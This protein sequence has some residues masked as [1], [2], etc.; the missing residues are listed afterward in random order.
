MAAKSDANLLW[1]GGTQGV[2]HQR[3]ESHK[4][5]NVPEGQDDAPT[6]KEGVWVACDLA[7]D[8]AKTRF[9]EPF[10]YFV[11]GEDFDEV[12]EV[13]PVRLLIGRRVLQ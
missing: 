2:I 9:Q 8:R 6:V 10:P 12:R 13:L 11:E 7:E 1:E 4:K 5:V 3:G